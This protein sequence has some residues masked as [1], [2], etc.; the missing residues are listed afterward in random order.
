MTV[1][2]RAWQLLL[3]ISICSFHYAFAQNATAISVEKQNVIYCGFDNPIAIAMEKVPCSELK[4]SVSE[5]ATITQVSDCNYNVRADQVGDVL[6][7]VEGGGT[8]F[9]KRLRAKRMPDP[10]AV[11]SNGKHGGILSV[12][13]AQALN[14]VIARVSGFD[15]DATCAMQS[16]DVV[17][18]QMRKDVVMFTNQG[19]VFSGVIGVLFR[20]LQAGDTV[21]FSNIRCRC[22]GDVAART[23]TGMTFYVK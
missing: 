18:K 13:E 16:F 8:I 2:K 22:P 23:L 6:I 3:L 19:A 17:I 1:Q 12:G 15:M 14:G 9:K 20:G 11:A 7:T 21:I 5:G 10:I 4:V